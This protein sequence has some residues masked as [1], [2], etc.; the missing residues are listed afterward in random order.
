VSRVN[1]F[2][3]LFSL[4][5]LLGST[6]VATINCL[7]FVSFGCTDAVKLFHSSTYTILDEEP[8]SSRHPDVVNQLLLDVILA[9]VDKISL[10]TNESLPREP[11]ERSSEGA[12]QKRENRRTASQSGLALLNLRIFMA[13]V[14]R[15]DA[16]GHSG[17][18][19]VLELGDH[20]P[21]HLQYRLYPLFPADQESHNR[22]LFPANLGR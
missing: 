7:L 6:I 1:I 3:V 4:Q 5:R 12:G 18:L 9:L 14:L 11:L 10:D 21:P 8:V 20:R 22:T 2:F 19:L 16:P 15:S 17:P 13:L